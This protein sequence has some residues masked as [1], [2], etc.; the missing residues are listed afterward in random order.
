MGW[1]SSLLGGNDRQLADTKYEG[2]ESATDRASRRR[3]ESH[4][5]NLDRHARKQQ[6]REDKF[7]RD[8]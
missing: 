1:L 2:R 3:R 5:R 6:A 4:H 8:L 7:W